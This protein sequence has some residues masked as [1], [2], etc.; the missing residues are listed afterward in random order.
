MART[1]AEAW[2]VLKPDMRTSGTATAAGRSGSVES[3]SVS[4]ARTSWSSTRGE[5]SD[6]SSG[7]IGTYA[8]APP[9]ASMNVSS[10]AS[11]NRSSCASSSPAQSTPSGAQPGLSSA[12]RTNLPRS[13]QRGGAARGGG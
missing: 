5:K 10:I 9:S 1:A 4:C 13:T 8:L 3:R 2:T 11:A 12:W 7:T 6:C